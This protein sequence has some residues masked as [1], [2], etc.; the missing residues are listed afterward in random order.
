MINIKKLYEKSAK[1]LTFP[2]IFIVLWITLIDRITTHKRII[3]L[4]F[5]EIWEFFHGDSEMMKYIIGNI[6]MLVPLGVLIRVWFKNIESVWKVLFI[7]LTVS[8]TIEILQ[9]ITTR[10]LFEFD[11][12]IH[13]TLGAVAG[14]MA[15][16][17]VKIVY[18]RVDSEF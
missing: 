17:K 5:W 2:Y 7:G 16:G 12:I 4:P 13:N 11:D 9:L 6:I 15:V 1:I 3:K 14:F 18:E 10:G 8:F